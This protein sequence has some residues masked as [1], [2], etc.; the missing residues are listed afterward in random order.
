MSYSSQTLLSKRQHF[1]DS[2]NKERVKAH[3]KGQQIEWSED[4]KRENL[5]N[6]DNKAYIPLLS[7]LKVT[8]SL[9]NL[10]KG[11]RNVIHLVNII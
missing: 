11:I 5:D 1:D 4:Y 10:G 7:N 2:K 3:S 8:N 9:F 6:Y